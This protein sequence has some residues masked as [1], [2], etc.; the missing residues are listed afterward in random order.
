MDDD[1]FDPKKWVSPAKTRPQNDFFSSPNRTGQ[2]EDGTADFWR[3]AAASSRAMPQDAPVDGTPRAAQQVRA[4]PS[5]GVS[6]RRMLAYG[7]STAAVS[8]DLAAFTFSGGDATGDT[9]QTFAS[10]TTTV[11]DLDGDGLAELVV[12]LPY[13]TVDKE[14]GRAHV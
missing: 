1:T 10:D 3:E 11:A 14:I 2:G 5:T 12:T 4:E 6:R 9:Y 8:A 13:E 7:A